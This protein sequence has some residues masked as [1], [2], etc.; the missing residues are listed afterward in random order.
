MFIRDS[1]HS[2]KHIWN[3]FL[4]SDFVCCIYIP[5][6]IILFGTLCLR[7]LVSDNVPKIY[8]LLLL[9]IAVNVMHSNDVVLDGP[10]P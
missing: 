5:F 6:C 4:S 2:M 10:S 8:S 1:Y 3:C 7:Y 9:T